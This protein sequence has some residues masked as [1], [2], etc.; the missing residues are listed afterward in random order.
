MPPVDDDD[1]EDPDDDDG[2]FEPDVEDEDDDGDSGD[3][4]NIDSPTVERLSGRFSGGNG[5]LS[6]VC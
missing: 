4:C 5:S 1:E 6:L 2:D 3:R